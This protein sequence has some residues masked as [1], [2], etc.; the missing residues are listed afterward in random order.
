MDHNDTK[1]MYSLGIAYL[2]GDVVDRN[3]TKAF[4]WIK[5]AAD[6]CGDARALYKLATMYSQGV[7]HR[8]K[9]Q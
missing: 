4:E 1:A 9:S 8:K 7:G 3:F 5:R 6:D 2:R